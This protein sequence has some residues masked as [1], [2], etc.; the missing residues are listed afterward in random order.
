MKKI[1]SVMLLLAIGF[2]LVLLAACG[3]E[4]QSSG[5]P[6]NSDSQTNSDAGGSEETI[7]LKSAD[8]VSATSPYTQ[9]MEKFINDLDSTTNGKIQVN[10]YPAGQLGS[11]TEIVEGVKLGSIDFAITGI[12]PG[13]QVVNGF[14]APYL[15]TSGEQLSKVINGDIG[16]QIIEQIENEN[17]A[18]GLKVVGFA[19]N[20]PRMVTTKGKNIEKPSDMK[21]FKIRVPEVPTYLD[22]FKSLGASPTPIAFTE[23]YT[24]LQTGT[25]DGQE[26]PFQ[27]IY[28]SSF[29]EVQDTIIETYHSFPA[30]FFIMNEDLYNSLSPEQQQKIEDSWKKASA[31]IQ[32][33]FDESEATYIQQLKD[34]GMTFIE[35]DIEAFKEATKDVREKY[36][37]ESFGQ[38][39]Y[40]QIQELSN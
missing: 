7:K 12:I 6:Q 29:Y 1:K 21:G 5:E 34:E 22:T 23:L 14:I 16:K 24:G 38:E 10:H 28:D 17:A 15:F 27:I 35:P 37:K 36:A 30:R 9:G 11:D 4:S 25:V 26:N 2:A 8:V 32:Q 31:F 39:I 3:G 18:K 40:E 19:Y 20:A 33:T 13:S